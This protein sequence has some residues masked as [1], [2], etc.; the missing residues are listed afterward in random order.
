MQQRGGGDDVG[1][2]V[3]QPVDLVG[4]AAQQR[5]RADVGESLHRSIQRVG[6]DAGDLDQG[7]VDA[8]VLAA[9]RSGQ[10]GNGRTAAGADLHGVGPSGAGAAQCS[11]GQQRLLVAAAVG[12]C[13]QVAGVGLA[14]GR[15]QGHGGSSGRLAPLGRDRDLSDGRAGKGRGK[16]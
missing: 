5:A 4:V 13:V 2:T 1:R 16:R 7:E 12:R 6:D 11:V 3:E 8:P 15:E 14:V 9:Q 10:G